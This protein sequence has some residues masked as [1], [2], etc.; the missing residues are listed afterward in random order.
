MV[1]QA[2]EYFEK[3]DRRGSGTGGARMVQKKQEPKNVGSGGWDFAD[4]GEDP[5]G[6]S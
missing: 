2:K 4:S 3:R 5:R 6:G 1:A